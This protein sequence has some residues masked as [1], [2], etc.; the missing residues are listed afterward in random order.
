MLEEEKLNLTKTGCEGHGILLFLLFFCSHLPF[1]I[2]ARLK[3]RLQQLFLDQW[4]L[5][6]LFF[7]TP[8]PSL[9]IPHSSKQHGDVGDVPDYANDG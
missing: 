9:P 4:P 8:L 2:A 5:V 1:H 6:L 7:P 3:G